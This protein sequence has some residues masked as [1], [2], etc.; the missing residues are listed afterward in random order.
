M[1]VLKEE[2]RKREDASFFK[3][4]YEFNH[5]LSKR[6]TQHFAHALLSLTEAAYV[7]LIEFKNVDKEIARQTILQDYTFD[8]KRDVP[9]F[10]KD[11]NQALIVKQKEKSSQSVPKR[12]QKH[13]VN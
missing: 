10:L 3:E 6:F 11:F 4:F 1:K 13:L 12:Q 7:Y 2:S 9:R 8:G 5:F